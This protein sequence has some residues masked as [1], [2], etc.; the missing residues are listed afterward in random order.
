MRIGLA[1]GG[2]G[3]GAAP[4]ALAAAAQLLHRPR[5]PAEP[6][7]DEAGGLA[8]RAVVVVVV[9]LLAV[10]PLPVVSLQALAYLLVLVLVRARAR[11]CWRPSRRTSC[12]AWRS[13]W[14]A[15]W[16]PTH[17]RAGTP[18]PTASAGCAA[19]LSFWTCG[20]ASA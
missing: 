2:E 17:R 7:Q 14:T 20:A 16:P 8:P 12:L 19:T 9:Q 11:R 4:S 1:R 3:E 5:L 18:W 10:L 15:T 13:S 6:Q